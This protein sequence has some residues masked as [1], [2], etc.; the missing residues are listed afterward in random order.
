MKQWYALY[1]LLCSYSTMALKFGI[2]EDKLTDPRL[3]FFVISSDLLVSKY[4]LQQWSCLAK[5]VNPPPEGILQYWFRLLSLPQDLLRYVYVKLVHI[6]SCGQRSWCR[7][8]QDTL[9][10]FQMANYGEIDENWMKM[11]YKSQ[12]LIFGYWLK[13]SGSAKWVCKYMT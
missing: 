11:W 9:N 1:V 7:N 5:L 12:H 6:D 3:W 8:V 4:R 13:T 10:E 2:P